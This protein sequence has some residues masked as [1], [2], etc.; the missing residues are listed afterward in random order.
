MMV[1]GSRYTIKGFCLDQFLAYPIEQ[2]IDVKKK[3]LRKP[4]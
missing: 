1:E 3:K 4:R 2:L